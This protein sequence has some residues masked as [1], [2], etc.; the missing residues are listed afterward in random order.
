MN[1]AKEKKVDNEEKIQL[2][3]SNFRTKTFYI[4]YSKLIHL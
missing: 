2:M 1:T 4:H 3:H